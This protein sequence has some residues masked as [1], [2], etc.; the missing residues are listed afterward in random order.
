M[1]DDNTMSHVTCMDKAVLFS[2]SEMSSD[3]GLWQI[4]GLR[5]AH[6]AAVID[7]Q[8][9]STHEYTSWYYSQEAFKLTYSG[10]I[11]PIPDPSMWPDVEG[12]PP[13]PPKKH[14]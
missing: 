7:Y 8:G 9:H 10:S 4:S 6:A 11:S 2:P 14:I 1:E 13:D 12:A 3:C 5:C